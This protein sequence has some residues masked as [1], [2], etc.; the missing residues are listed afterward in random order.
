MLWQP[1][2]LGLKYKLLYA[3]LLRVQ[4][5]ANLTIKYFERVQIHIHT[6]PLISLPEVTEGVCCVRISLFPAGSL[7]PSCEL[8]LLADPKSQIGRG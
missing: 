3:S 6:P 7:S 1:G 4:L 2:L 8:M 5:S